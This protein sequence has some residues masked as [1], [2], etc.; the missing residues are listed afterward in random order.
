MLGDGTWSKSGTQIYHT[1]SNKLADDFQKLCLHAGWC[2]NKKLH[3]KAGTTTV[4][5]GQEV[6]TKHDSYRITVVKKYAKPSVN[7]GHAKRQGFQKEYVYDYEGPVF[8]LSVTSE[9]F[10]V[11]RNGKAVW[12]GNS[13]GS[14]GPVVKHRHRGYCKIPA[15]LR[16][17]RQHNQIAG[18]TWKS[19]VPRII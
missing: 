12:S 9:V 1:S 14:N 3:I 18:T 15:S 7:H 11:R 17:G 5:R 2:A 6:I 10:M 19:M 8:C 16:Y 4:I 13:R